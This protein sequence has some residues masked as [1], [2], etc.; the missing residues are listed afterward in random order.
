MLD[1]YKVI[2]WDFDGVL[3]D[4][5]SVRDFGFEKVLANYPKE[6]V[7]QLMFFH[8]D[9][10]GLSRYVK[11]RYFFESILNQKVTDEEIIELSNEFSIIMRQSL[12]NPDLII[13][14]SMNYVKKKYDQGVK[15]YIVSGSDQIELRFL[16]D[17]LDI[18]KFFLSI[19]GSPKS[20]NELV[21]HI[22]DSNKY[23]K[24]EIV[25][26]GDSVNDYEAARLNKIS[27]YGFN[28]SKI[29]QLDKYITS[30]GGME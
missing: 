10:G 29:T 24:E 2:L 22:I 18:S 6:S 1:N 12:T 20:K 26:I 3:M 8:R 4:S 9:N 28:N 15:M 13:H 23:S 19:Y 17:V 7:E 30:F 27:F 21:R 5:N 11:F 25:L 14:D 16:C